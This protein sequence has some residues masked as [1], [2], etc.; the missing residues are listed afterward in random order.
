M[1]QT[2]YLGLVTFKSAPFLLGLCPGGPTDLGIAD[3]GCH[4]AEK[5]KDPHL[6]ES[7]RPQMARDEVAT[8]RLCSLWV[9]R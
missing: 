4:Q 3:L 7:R 9:N 6:M 1:K 8:H 2:T 5:A